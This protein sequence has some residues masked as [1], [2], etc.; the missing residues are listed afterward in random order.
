MA[1]IILNIPDAVLPRVVD[2][3]ASNNGYPSFVNDAQGKL[4]PNPQTK[5]QFTKQHIVNYLKQQVTQHESVTAVTGVENSV[6][7]D[8]SIT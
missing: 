3:V 4:I 6:K 7:T 1:Q 2:A 5:G 8:I